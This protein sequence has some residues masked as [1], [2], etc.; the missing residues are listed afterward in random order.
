MIRA[1]EVAAP[2]SPSNE[3]R[4][5]CST[6]RWASAIQV[7]KVYRS[8]QEGEARYSPAEVA[9]VEVQ[10][11]VILKRCNTL[12]NVRFCPVLCGSHGDVILHKWQRLLAKP[13]PVLRIAGT[14]AS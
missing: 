12:L 9:S 13:M 3:I 2:L 1:L 8:S 6:S 5:W 7:I 14:S 10:S 4:N 11:A